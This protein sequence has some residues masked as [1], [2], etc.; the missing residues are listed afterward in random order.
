MKNTASAVFFI[1]RPHVPA[2]GFFVTA[3][4][5]SHAGYA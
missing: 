3:V 5:V 4:T 1:Y 2:Y